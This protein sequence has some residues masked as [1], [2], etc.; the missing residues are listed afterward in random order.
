MPA[1]VVAL[2]TN[3]VR[4]DDLAC[5]A[6]SGDDQNVLLRL[7]IPVGQ[8]ITGW[9]AANGRTVVNADATLDLAEM[10]VMFAPP[11]RSAISAPMKDGEHV[12]VLTA[13]ST[14]E[15]GFTETHRYSFEYVAAACLEA[16]QPAFTE[17]SRSVVA[18]PKSR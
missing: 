12:S 7:T 16:K 2:F 4:S 8:R 13:Y 5:I 6:T 10:A 9:A 3:D 11:L 1:T 15:S 18:F 14:K 17:I